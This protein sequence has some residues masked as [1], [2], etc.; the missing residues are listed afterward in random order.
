MAFLVEFDGNGTDPQV[1]PSD[2][3][4]EDIEHAAQPFVNSLDFAT[5]V[6]CLD[7]LP[8]QARTF[9][10][11]NRVSGVREEPRQVVLALA[12]RVLQDSRK[13]A[14]RQRIATQPVPILHSG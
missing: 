12:Q 4:R 13:L 10:R 7:V 3:Q 2:V 5:E 6:G 11:L 1:P 8:F 9:G 14:L